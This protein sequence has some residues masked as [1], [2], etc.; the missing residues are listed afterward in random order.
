MRRKHTMK[1]ITLDSK[2]K[3]TPNEWIEYWRKRGCFFRINLWKFPYELH[4]EIMA[5]VKMTYR[6]FNDHVAY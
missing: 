4:E 3:K 1:K 2:I 5:G 6:Q